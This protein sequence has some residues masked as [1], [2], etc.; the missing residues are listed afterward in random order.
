MRYPD[1]IF[2]VR[3][4]HESRQVTQ[5]YGFYDECIRK[6]GST[7]TVWR[8]CTELFDYLSLGAVIGSDA[9]ILAVHG[10]LSPYFDSLDEI[11]RLDRKREVPHE[12]AMCDIMWSDPEESISEWGISPR[13][14]GHL[15][16]SEVVDRFLHGNNL[17]L[18]VRA[19]QLVMEGYRMIFD[20]KLCT[21]WSAP[22]YCYRCGNT[23]AVMEIVSTANSVS[24]KTVMTTTS[25]R[26]SMS[27]LDDVDP[28]IPEDPQNNGILQQQQL[29]FSY[30]FKTFNAAPLTDREPPARRPYTEY[31]I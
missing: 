3:G 24:P 22:N 11:R 31:F 28:T 26:S 21:I 5:V 6:Y 25:S 2:L 23:A 16:G 15:F 27:E 18:I 13:G 9:Q 7:T 30:T 19:H 4:N 29:S 10:G 12:G 1:R 20:G 14:A 8:Y 17:S